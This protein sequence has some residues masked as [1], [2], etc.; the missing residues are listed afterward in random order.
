MDN[1]YEELILEV[2]EFV[3]GDIITDSEPCD[4][5]GPPY[6]WGDEGQDY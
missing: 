6:C 5:Q 2:I 4:T 1:Q 3:S